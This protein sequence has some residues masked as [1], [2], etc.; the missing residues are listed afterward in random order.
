M[1]QPAAPPPATVPSPFVH[2]ENALFVGIAFES[3]FYG[4]LQPSFESFVIHCSPVTLM[5]SGI[6]FLLYC[7]TIRN[8]FLRNSKKNSAAGTLW[9]LMGFL[10]IQQIALF[11]AVLCNIQFGVLAFVYHRDTPGGPVAYQILHSNVA[12]AYASLATFSVCNWFQ[13]VVLV[14]I[15]SRN[16]E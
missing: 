13:D 7:L 9:K 3:I 5:L 11:I 14:R 12:P 1:S 2:E 16:F 10:T 6:T 4:A 15:S 8:L